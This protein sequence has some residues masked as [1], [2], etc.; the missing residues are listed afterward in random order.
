M[1]SRVLND[2]RDRDLL[3]PICGICRY[4]NICGGCRARAYEL[5]ND[6]LATDIGCIKNK[7]ILE[8]KTE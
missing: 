1:N 5:S 3:K 8:K 2:L 7:R 4:R 6:Y